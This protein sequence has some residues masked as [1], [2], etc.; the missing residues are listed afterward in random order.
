MPVRRRGSSPTNSLTHGGR[1]TGSPTRPDGIKR[2][3]NDAGDGVTSFASKARGLVGA[4][5][6][7]EGLRQTF[8]FIAEGVQDAAALGES[9]NRINVLFGDLGSEIIDFSENSTAALVLTQREA[10][11]AGRHLRRTRPKQSASPGNRPSTSVRHSPG[12]SSCFS[13]RSSSSTGRR[14]RPGPRR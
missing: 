10:L 6:A 4:L 3:V 13:S 11:D 5:A 1:R 7:F 9:L 2:E 8:R 12:S 14:W